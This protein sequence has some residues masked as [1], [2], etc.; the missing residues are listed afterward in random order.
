VTEAIRERVGDELR[1]AL[2]RP[3]DLKGFDKPLVLY[4]G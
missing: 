2:A 3:Y 1:D 4:R